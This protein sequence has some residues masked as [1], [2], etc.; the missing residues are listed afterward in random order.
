MDSKKK[1]KDLLNASI[2][3]P[4]P[5]VMAS[6]TQIFHPCMNSILSKLIEALVTFGESVFQER[7]SILFVT[8]CA[9]N[10]FHLYI[11]YNGITYI[12]LPLLWCNG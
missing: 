3:G 9:K 6:K 1:F 12:E 10:P 11:P 5:L 7:F 2:L 8:I 4:S